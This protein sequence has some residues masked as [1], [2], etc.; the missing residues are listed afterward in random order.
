MSFAP[1]EGNY[2]KTDE[3]GALKATVTFKGAGA[4]VIPFKVLEWYRDL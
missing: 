3:N 1:A 4:Y 2:G